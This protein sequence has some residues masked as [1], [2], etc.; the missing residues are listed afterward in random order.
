MSGLLPGDAIAR[1]QSIFGEKAVLVGRSVADPLFESIASDVEAILCLVTDRIDA[2]LLARC[3]KLRVVANVAVGIDNIDVNECRARSIVVTN[4]PDI[5]TDATA[6]LAFGLLLTAA[7]RVAEGDREIR[8]DRFPRFGL[9][10]MLGVPVH[11]QTL[12]IIGLGRIGQAMARRSR[13]F[14]MPILYSQRNRMSV[15]LERALGAT[16][17]DV[18][19]LFREADFVTLH[20]PLT[21]ETVQI[22]SRARIDSMKR[23]AV[24]VNTSRGP[25]VDEEALTDALETNRIFGAG[26]DVFVA[27]P[28]ISERF[29][30]LS[31]V[32]LTPHIGSAD[33]GTRIAM[34]ALAAENVIRVLSHQQALTAVSST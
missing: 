26:L 5:L 8:A 18:D 9:S 28:R 14:G 6:D 16:Y 25:C 11:G 29:R 1:I 31:N 34:A 10:T 21:P 24:L 23:T 19:T 15:D 27:E 20:C 7:R 12:G 3:P 17:V 4:T 32:V 22:A 30:T 13:G 2:S 33:V